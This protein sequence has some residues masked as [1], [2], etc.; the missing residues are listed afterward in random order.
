[1]PRPGRA[2]RCPV[3]VWVNNSLL[4]V[5][6]TDDK[7]SGSHE[8][9]EM[10]GEFAPDPRNVR[11]LKWAIYIMSALLVIGVIVV[12]VTIAMRSNKLAS[13]SATGFGVLDVPVPAGTVI[14]K[15]SI[16][17][18]R[19]AVHVRKGTGGAEQIVI[20]NMRRGIIEGRVRL[21]EEK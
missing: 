18:D 12:G 20:I 8:F 10:G 2:G 11:L 13:K 9:D 15:Y 14:S 17:N 16:D 1:M 21:T 3:A 6:M 4:D 7:I 5:C 19:I